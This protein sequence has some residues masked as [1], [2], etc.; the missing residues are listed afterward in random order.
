MAYK[1]ISPT[2]SFVQFGVSSVVTSCNFKDIA[3]CLPVYADD[4]IA[5]QFVIEADSEEEA[6][7]LC[8]LDGENISLGIA[9][10]CDE[11]NLIT[12]TERPDRY[13][14]SPFQVLYNWAHGVPEFTTV[15]SSGG[16]FVIKVSLL[17]TYTFCSN[18]FQRIK[19]DCHT[20]VLEY[21]NEDDAF[22]FNYCNSQPVDSSDTVCEPTLITFT[23]QSTLAIP[24]TAAMIDKYGN[25]P[26]L[27]VWIYDGSGQLVNMSVSQSFDNYPPT[28]INID[29]GGPAT[30]VLKIS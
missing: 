25:V 26:T 16:C 8:T 21:S 22:G 2:N 30:G 14:I 18:C 3:L 10:D 20:S 12:F 27:K 11:D 17:D 24:Y 29:M 6:D 23:N 13:R 28:Q 15:I 1:I 5:F 4:D 9:E 19:D 7:A